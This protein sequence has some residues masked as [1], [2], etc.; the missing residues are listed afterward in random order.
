MKPSLGEVGVLHLVI[1]NLFSVEKGGFP[2]YLQDGND[3]ACLMGHL[4]KGELFYSSA[5]NSAL[6]LCLINAAFVISETRR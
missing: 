4:L 2:L 1:L 6:R 5:F 3:R